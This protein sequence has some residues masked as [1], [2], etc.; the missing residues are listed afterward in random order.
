MGLK[1]ERKDGARATWNRNI[2]KISMIL[3]PFKAQRGCNWDLRSGARW[4]SD[5]FH[6]VRAQNSADECADPRPGVR[7]ELDRPRSEET[8]ST[9]P[10]F[11]NAAGI[12]VTSCLRSIVARGQSGLALRSTYARLRRNNACSRSFDGG[13]R[14]RPCLI[15][16]NGVIVG[17]PWKR[18]DPL[19]RAKPGT[20]EGKQALERALKQAEEPQPALSSF[21]TT[22]G[23]ESSR[24]QL[25]LR[26]LSAF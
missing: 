12:F 22:P 17:N 16:A 23:Q 18:R 4:A 6:P 5:L 21:G 11:E 7:G 24:L 26:A 1:R 3:S 25:W 8:R 10:V 20:E 19:V 9:P 13:E 2:W 14:R 15:I